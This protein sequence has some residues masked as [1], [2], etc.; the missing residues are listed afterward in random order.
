M[1]KNITFTY[2][3]RRRQTLLQC[4]TIEILNLKVKTCR[5]KQKKIESLLSKQAEKCIYFYLYIYNRLLFDTNIYIWSIA[6]EAPVVVLFCFVLF[7]VNAHGQMRFLFGCFEFSETAQHRKYYIATVNPS[8]LDMIMFSAALFS[9][10]SHTSSNPSKVLAGLW[11][12]SLW[13][14]FGVGSHSFSQC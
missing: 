4:W 7:S 12:E 11:V 14:Q 6:K 13:R 3:H 5:Y 9:H 8:P 10:S 1:M 2:T